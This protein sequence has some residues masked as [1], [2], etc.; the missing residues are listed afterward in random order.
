MASV[1]ENSTVPLG[2]ERLRLAIP[3]QETTQ[4][5][6]KPCKVVINRELF[7]RMVQCRSALTHR[8]FW[9]LLDTMLR[10]RYYNRFRVS[11]S[12]IAHELGCSTGSVCDA[13]RWLRDNEI[14]IPYMRDGVLF[15][16]F[17][18]ELLWRGTEPQRRRCVR[19]LNEAKEAMQAKAASAATVP[20]SYMLH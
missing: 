11:P 6:L 15:Y 9:D 18:P 12:L 19:A 8:V 16:L 5:P 2:C 10:D 1:T 17:N 3:A 14:I 4:Q 13:L 20:A 7:A